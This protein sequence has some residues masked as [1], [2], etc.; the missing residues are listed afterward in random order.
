MG[1]DVNCSEGLW[2]C[3]LKKEASVPFRNRGCL[4]VYGGANW[5]LLIKSRSKG[6]Y[7]LMQGGR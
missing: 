3:Q 4:L 2:R 1:C 7:Y 6:A 5:G